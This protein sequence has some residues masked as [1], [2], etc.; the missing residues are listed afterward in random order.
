MP[1]SFW[2]L[3]IGAWM[4]T[5]PS[6]TVSSPGSGLP[7]YSMNSIMSSWARDL[8]S[9]PSRDPTLVSAPPTEY[10]TSFKNSP[11]LGFET[12]LSSNADAH[13]FLR[14][15]THYLPPSPGTVVDDPVVESVFAS[16]PELDGVRLDPVAT[17][18]RGAW[19]LTPLVLGFERPNPLFQ[20]APVLDGPALLGSPGPET[21][22]ARAAHEVGVGLFLREATGAAFY[23]DLTRQLAPV[24][25]Q[26]TRGVRLEIFGFSSFVVGVEDE[27]LLVVAFEEDGAGGGTTVSS[28]GGQDHGIRLVEVRVD[29]PLEPLVELDYGIGIHVGFVQADAGVFPAKTRDI[30]AF[31]T[32]PRFQ[33]RP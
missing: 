33:G 5:S 3:T 8:I 18:E 2:G 15:Q 12:H 29:D 6:G 10:V 23:P 11:L 19:D 26:G 21:T 24:E 16:L 13:T 7:P 1:M 31:S 28:S 25:Q 20:N 27:T 9:S 14:L 17:P 22:S 4:R 30:H 32:S